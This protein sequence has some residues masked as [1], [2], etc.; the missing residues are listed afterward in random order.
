MSGTVEGGWKTRETNYERHGRDHY[1]KIGAI[2]GKK[3]VPKGFA[4]NTE[5]ARLAGQKGGKISRRGK[6]ESANSI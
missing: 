3:K 5:R 1:R 2:G 4:M 6:S